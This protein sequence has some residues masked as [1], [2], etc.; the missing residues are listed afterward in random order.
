MEI[1]S[2]VVNS[3]NLDLLDHK[4]TFFPLTVKCNTVPVFRNTSQI[5][6]VSKIRA[7]QGA[8]RDVEI[9]DFFTMVVGYVCRL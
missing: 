8:Y 4:Q 1:K 6:H 5:Y 3:E 2:F 9:D 7:P